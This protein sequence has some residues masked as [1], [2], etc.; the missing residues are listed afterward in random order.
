MAF[1][2]YSKKSF[3]YVT[4]FKFWVMSHLK[5]HFLAICYRSPPKLMNPSEPCQTLSKF[6][7]KKQ[8]MPAGP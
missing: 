2:F 1:N 6:G 8:E 4:N 7:G 3:Y 5:T